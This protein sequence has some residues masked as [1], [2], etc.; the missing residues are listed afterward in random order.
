GRETIDAGGNDRPH[1]RGKVDTLNRPGEPIGSPR[2]GQRTCLYQGPDAFLEEEGITLRAVDQQ[3]AQI[4]QVRGVPE[5]ALQVL[6]CAG[7]R[8]GVEADLL[9][10][11]L[12]PPAVRILRPVVHEEE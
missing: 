10:V 8:Q 7:G 11:R 6:L 9:V 5:Q 4:R 3:S 12:A 2:S 1:G